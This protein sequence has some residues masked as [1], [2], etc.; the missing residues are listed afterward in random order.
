MNDLIS[1]LLQYKAMAVGIWLGLFFI[2]E[3]ALPHA[4]NI[5]KGR[6]NLNRL[7]RNFGLI[8]VNFAL[9]PLVIIPISAYASAHALGLTADFRQDWWQ[10]LTGLLLDLL[11]LDFCIYWWH[12]F[13]HIMP[14]FW[15]FHEIHHLDV[16][17]DVTTAL[18]FHFGEVLLSAGI[19]AGIVILLDL[20]IFSIV[21]FETLVLFSSIFQHSNL[22]IPLSIDRLLS[23]VIVTP[24][25]HW[26][27]HHAVRIDTDSNYSNTLTIWDR[28]FGSRSQHQRDNQ[29]P[30]GVG[31]EPEKGFLHLIWRPVERR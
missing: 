15:R 27:H 20:P 4:L 5:P 14:F 29:M 2:L 30:I 16:T 23:F 18:R 10:G 26:M 12:R 7:G 17:L 24:G 22:K 31:N 21:V 3:R 8:A 11:I 28:L 9:S 25:W 13:M 6:D 19:R 1:N